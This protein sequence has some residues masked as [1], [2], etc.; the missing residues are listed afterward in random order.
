MMSSTLFRLSVLHATFMNPK[1]STWERTSAAAR[2]T[3]LALEEWPHIVSL[4]EKNSAKTCSVYDE[5]CGACSRCVA[6]WREIVEMIFG[7]NM[8]KNVYELRKLVESKGLKLGL[9]YKDK[10]AHASKQVKNFF[11]KR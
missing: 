6:E 2:F 1:A 7:A 11:T 9:S 3:T 5:P 10:I 4:V 8:T